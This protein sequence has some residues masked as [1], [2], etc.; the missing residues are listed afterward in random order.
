MA[1]QE[2]LLRKI[3]RGFQITLPP[4]F[5]EQLGLRIGDHVRIEQAGEKLI[6]TPLHTR[7]QRLAEELAKALSEQVDS[8]ESFDEE[9]AM[10]FAIDQIRQYR[11]AHK[12]KQTH[13]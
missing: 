12:N 1:R 11:R 13:P 3:S 10:Q 9:Q 5:R 8:E 2:I 6:V 4:Q 7:R